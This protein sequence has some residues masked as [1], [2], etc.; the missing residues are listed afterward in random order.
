MKKKSKKVLFAIITIIVIVA[1][2]II[3]RLI[4]NIKNENDKLNDMMNKIT[5]SYQLL[6][7]N[8]DTYN[9]NRQTLSEYLD[10]YY[11]ENLDEDYDNYIKLLSEQE[12]TIEAMHTSIDEISNNCK[13]RLFS[14]KEVN[15]ICSTYQ[16]YYEMV[17]NIF[18][19][20]QAQVNKM[21]NKYN[22]NA[23]NP[24]AEY[25]PTKITDYI[26]YNQDGEYLERED[27]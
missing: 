17:V 7:T 23:T 16:E 1:V 15:N 4:I 25:Q 24:L 20:D 12:D 14:R 6:E 21:I 19:N 13:D 18:I 3:T 10:N 2:V 26:D 5:E 8:I 11:T 9:K 22:E 27:K